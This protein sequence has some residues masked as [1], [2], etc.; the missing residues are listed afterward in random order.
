MN[1]RPAFLITIFATTLVA[2]QADD[3]GRQLQE[4]QALAIALRPARPQ[5]NFTSKATLTVRDSDNHRRRTPLGVETAITPD[6]WSVAY[7]PTGDKAAESLTVLFSTNA[8][9]RYI[10]AAAPGAPAPEFGKAWQSFLGSDFWI[11][12]LGLE[13]LYW[14]EQRLIKQELSSGRLC[15]ILYSVNP[16]TN[17]YASV[18]SAVDAERHVILNADAFNAAGIRI[19]QFAVTGAIEF[20]G[21]TSYSLKMADSIKNSISEIVPDR[22]PE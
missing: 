19:K 8:P 5:Q 4:G 6:G 18:R 7:R 13:F 20:G 17:G 1:P 14:P 11:A 9:P 3:L 10:Q 16:S 12:D 2:L 15:N 21:G 22:P